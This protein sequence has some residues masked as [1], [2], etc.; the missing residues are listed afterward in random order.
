MNQWKEFNIYLILNRNNGVEI[1]PEELKE[2]V[3]N[4]AIRFGGCT[5]HP[6]LHGSWINKR[7][8][9][10]QDRVMILQVAAENYPDLGYH[11]RA[12]AQL[13]LERL[14]QECVFI[15]SRDIGVLSLFNGQN[16]Q[17]YNELGG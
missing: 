16:S 5:L 4:T 3:D 8:V 7:G 17:H 10:H 1:K 14:N 13:I 12:L 15:T 11:V 6:S 2:I 9:C